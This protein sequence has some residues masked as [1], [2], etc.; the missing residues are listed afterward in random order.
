MEVCAVCSKTPTKS[1]IK[2][3]LKQNG[4]TKSYC[5]TC[6]FE[7]A[8]VAFNIPNLQCKCG[9]NLKLLW[10]DNIEELIR[11]IEESNTIIYSCEEMVEKITTMEDL[12]FDEETINYIKASKEGNAH[13]D[14][15]LS[16]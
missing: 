8:K 5:E 3:D 2:V 7:G 9:A 4:E 11:E 12:I 13:S 14:F 1:I 6:L 10:F 16:V 15:I